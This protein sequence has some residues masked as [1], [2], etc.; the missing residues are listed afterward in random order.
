MNLTTVRQ[1]W[2]TMA[3]LKG[4]ELLK[5]FTISSNHKVPATSF[6]PISDTC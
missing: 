1:L 3:R 6:S 4:T 2:K 5:S